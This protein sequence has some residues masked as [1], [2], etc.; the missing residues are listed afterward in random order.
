MNGRIL[1]FHQVQNINPNKWQPLA[2]ESFIDQSG[3]V[4]ANNT[5]EFLSPEWGKVTPFA[6]QEI[7]LDISRFSSGVYFIK[8]ITDKG[9]LM[10]KLLKK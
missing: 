8:V 5:P 1:N 7:D 4:V 6:L 9:T 2:F 3:N 10:Q